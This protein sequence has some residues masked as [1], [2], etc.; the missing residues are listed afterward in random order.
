MRARISS[1]SARQVAGRERHEHGAA[2]PVTTP[3][4]G[5]IGMEALGDRGVVRERGDAPPRPERE[6]R[7]Q[8]GDQRGERCLEE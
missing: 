6:R 2:K 5:A 1:G 4:R 7:R 8:Q 3:S